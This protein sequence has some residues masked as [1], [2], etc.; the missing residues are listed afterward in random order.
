MNKFATKAVRTTGVYQ[1]WVGSPTIYY[2]LSAGE[3]VVINCHATSTYSAM[4][5][6]WREGW[7]NGFDLDTGHDPNP[8]VPPCN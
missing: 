5:P 1:G 6:G 8:N 4:R 2:Y 3:T 7:V